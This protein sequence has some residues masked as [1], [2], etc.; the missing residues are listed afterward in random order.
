MKGSTHQKIRYPRGTVCTY[1]VS[2]PP[3]HPWETQHKNLHDKKKRSETKQKYE[4]EEEDGANRK[5]KM[6]FNNFPAV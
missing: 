5:K 6:E 1:I 3:I 2:P 4:K